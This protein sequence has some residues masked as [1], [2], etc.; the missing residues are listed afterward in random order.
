MSSK[1][2]LQQNTRDR[3]SPGRALARSA[4]D[5]SKEPVSHPIINV[6]CRRGLVKLDK[7]ARRKWCVRTRRLH[8][9]AAAR[10]ARS[11]ESMISEERT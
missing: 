4:R 10:P 11:S 3:T 2:R 1:V 7:V 8:I 6:R 9:Y 5:I